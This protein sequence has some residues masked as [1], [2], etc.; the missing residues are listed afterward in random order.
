MGLDTFA[1]RSPGDVVLSPEDQ[2]V[3]A[4]L[5]LP[6]CEWIGTGSFR[7]KLYDLAVLEVTGST[8]Y[9][10]WISPEE[11]AQMAAAL[12]ACP[13]ERAP[14]LGSYGSRRLTTAEAQALRDFFRVCAD[15]GLGLLG[16]W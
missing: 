3:F 4:A 12:E 8:L 6:L 15:R 13:P 2:A 11:V 14:E 1:S 5:D 10:E 9:Q 16:W 7:G